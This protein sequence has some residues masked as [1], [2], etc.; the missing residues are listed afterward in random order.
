M[1][2]ERD[3]SVSTREISMRFFASL[4]L[5]AAL[6]L[7]ISFAPHSAV[8]KAR[9]SGVENLVCSGSVV[10]SISFRHDRHGY[11]G[12]SYDGQS[13]PVRSRAGGFAIGSSGAVMHVDGRLADGGAVSL[14][15]TWPAKNQDSTGT[16]NCSKVG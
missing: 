7:A 11:S 10:G 13:Y 1:L 12:Y 8:A 6:G 15:F 5:V 2:A 4:G 9:K 3:V 14:R 16:A